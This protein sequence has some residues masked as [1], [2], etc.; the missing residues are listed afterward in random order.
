MS[1]ITSV[2]HSVPSDPIIS[3]DTTGKY[4]M[5]TLAVLLLQCGLYDVNVLLLVTSGISPLGV[6]A[7]YRIGEFVLQ[8][9]LFFVIMYMIAIVLIYLL[10][11]VL[12]YL[13]KHH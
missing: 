6:T 4:G 11:V 9:V 8:K 3:V 5:Y 13:Q 1:S 7:T 12:L 10:S 2:S